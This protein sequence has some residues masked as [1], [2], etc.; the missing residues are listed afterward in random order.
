MHARG[1]LYQLSYSLSV[2]QYFKE[3]NTPEKISLNVLL[4]F[5]R[6]ALKIIQGPRCSGIHQPGL[7]IRG[8]G[9]KGQF[10]V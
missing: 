10:G 3:N 8:L 5:H 2:Q 6:K 9:V 7:E 1:T 4:H